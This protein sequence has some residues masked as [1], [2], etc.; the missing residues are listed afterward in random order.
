MS[1]IRVLGGPV[2]REARL[3]PCQRA[4]EIQRSLWE[5]QSIN[6]A[7]HSVATRVV[8][9]V[10]P[11]TASSVRFDT[12]SFRKIRFKYSLIVPSVRCSSYAISLFCL[13]LHTRL[14]TCLSRKLRFGLSSAFCRSFGLPQA[15]QIL[16]PPPL[17]NSFPHRKQFRTLIKAVVSFINGSKTLSFVLIGSA[18]RKLELRTRNRLTQAIHMPMYRPRMASCSG[19]HRMTVL[20]LFTPSKWS[21][22]HFF[23][24]NGPSSP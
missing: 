9:W 24:R 19:E 4:N 7:T 17:W 1:G 22:M 5:H 15:E 8:W 14:T 6:Q 16:F 11:Q 20:V 10:T 23:L 21:A 12:P 3:A 13:A 18:F 2:F